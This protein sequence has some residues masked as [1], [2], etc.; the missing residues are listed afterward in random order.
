VSLLAQFIM[1]DV[2]VIGADWSAAPNE[3]CALLSWG[4]WG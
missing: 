2:V 3:R 1:K 4:F